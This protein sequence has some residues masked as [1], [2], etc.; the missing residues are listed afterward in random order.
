MIFGL[1]KPSKKLEDLEK[2]TSEEIMNLKPSDLLKYAKLKNPGLIVA[3]KDDY[4][5]MKEFQFSVPVRTIFI[6]KYLRN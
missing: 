2:M 1:F 3:I 4:W 6:N 5:N